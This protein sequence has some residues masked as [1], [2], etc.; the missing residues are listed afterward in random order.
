[1]VTV[2]LL[3]SDIVS[4]T[5]LQRAQNRGQKTALGREIRESTNAL[6]K[7]VGFAS[8]EVR[9]RIE[10]TRLM[11][12]YK[13]NEEYV[14]GNLLGCLTRLQLGPHY[15]IDRPRTGKFKNSVSYLGR[16]EWNSLPFYICCIDCYSHFKEEVKRL[17][18]FRYFNSISDG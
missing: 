7:E 4:K 9:V 11:F 2:F 5:K 14:E 6:H 10:L 18:N 17:Y 12:K 3:G 13:Y 16:T 1:M 15:K 8:W